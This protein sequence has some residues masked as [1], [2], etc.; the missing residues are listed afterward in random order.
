MDDEDDIHYVILIIIW[1][2]VIACCVCACY[3]ACVVCFSGRSYT[4][5]QESGAVRI[6]T[7]SKTCYYKVSQIDQ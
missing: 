1:I 3:L 7:L 5:D 2:R 6:I 4:P